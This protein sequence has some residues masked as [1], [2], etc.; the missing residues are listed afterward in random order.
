VYETVVCY[1]NLNMIDNKII[2]GFVTLRA[3]CLF[4]RHTE[5]SSYI[6]WNN[7]SSNAVF[8]HLFWLRKIH[9]DLHFLAQIWTVRMIGIKCS[10]C[11]SQN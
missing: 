6:A 8:A 7:V 11:T 5:H 9:T 1:K 10:K 2:Y 4:Y 3:G